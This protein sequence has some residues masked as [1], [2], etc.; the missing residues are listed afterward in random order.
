MDQNEVC[1]IKTFPFMT[2]DYKNSDFQNT[3]LK[4]K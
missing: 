1:K 4:K 3:S 2:H